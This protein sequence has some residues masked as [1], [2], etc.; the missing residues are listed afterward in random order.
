MRFA[1]VLFFLAGEGAGVAWKK[2]KWLVWDSC[3]SI[4]DAIFDRL[5]NDIDS[6]DL[7]SVFLVGVGR[8]D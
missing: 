1:C 2:R 4:T 5:V 6:I 7:D 8:I 3:V